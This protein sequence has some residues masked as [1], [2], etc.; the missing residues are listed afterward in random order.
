[1]LM[2]KQVGKIQRDFRDEKGASSG[3]VIGLI[4]AIILLIGAAAFGGW[5]YVQMNQFKNESD[6]KSAIAAKNASEAT[7]KKVTDELNAKFQEQYKQPFTRFTSPGVF[8]TVSFQYPKTWSQFISSNQSQYQV[9]FNPVSVPPINGQSTPFALRVLIS[10]QNY[11]QILQNYRGQ[12]SN[13]TLSSETLNTGVDSSAKG[14]LITGQFS[15][16][17]NGSMA[18]FPIMNGNYTLQIFSDS[19][20]F[21]PDMMN[22]V[23]PS[24]KFNL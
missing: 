14:V 11:S 13:G 6:Q 17:I 22:T 2:I 23:L 20:D 3:L 9:Y 8:G 16:S 15:N 1:M 19:S 21:V 10:P 24:L 5:A 7:E 4:F 12:I 18:A